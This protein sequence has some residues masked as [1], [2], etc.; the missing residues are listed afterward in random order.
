[1]LNNVKTI[2]LLGAALGFLLGSGGGFAQPVMA[3]TPVIFSVKFVCG[4]QT[5][6][7]N[8][9]EPTVRPG[10]YA[11]DIN[12]HNYHPQ[13]NVTLEK[14]VIL[15]VRGNDGIGREPSV[16]EPSNPETIVLPAGRATMDDCPA[17][18]RMAGLPPGNT[19][20][21]GFLQIRSTNTLNVMGVYTVTPPSANGPTSIDVESFTGKTL[22]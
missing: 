19:L 13:A 2:G 22:P 20:I 5:P 7:P 1:M 21:V 10:S 14:R 9:P 4:S 12:I 16:R 15:L 17:I 8:N 6:S 18:R 3:Q 11:T